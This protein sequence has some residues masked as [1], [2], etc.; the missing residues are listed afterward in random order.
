[1]AECVKNV[2]TRRVQV[3]VQESLE[4]GEER[5]PS[6]TRSSNGTTALQGIR[7]REHFSTGREHRF[8]ARFANFSLRRTKFEKRISMA[9]QATRSGTIRRLGFA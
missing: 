6:D 9:P 5:R 4:L 3:T 2:K 7:G 1:M 8:R